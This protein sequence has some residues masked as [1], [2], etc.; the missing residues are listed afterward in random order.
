[1]EMRGVSLGKVTQSPN[2]VIIKDFIHGS[3]CA[4]QTRHT[5]GNNN[6]ECMG[7]AANYRDDFL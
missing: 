1:M 3:N 6:S 4:R 7:W 2:W 5:T